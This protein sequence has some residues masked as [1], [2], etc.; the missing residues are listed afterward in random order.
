MNIIALP[1]HEP[2]IACH[3]YLGRHQGSSGEGCS[4]HSLEVPWVYSLEKVPYFDTGKV[5]ILFGIYYVPMISYVS[6]ILA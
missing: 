1:A 6:L 3:I 5:M 2:G 4:P